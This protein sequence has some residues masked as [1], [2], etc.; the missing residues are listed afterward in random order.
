M[1]ND[2]GARF[3]IGSVEFAVVN[4]G[5]NYYDAGA[6]FGV[7]PRVMWERQIPPLDDRY[8]MNLGLNCLL[9]RSQGQT[10][11][12]ESGI[13]GKPGD[14][15]SASPAAIAPRPNSRRGGGNSSTTMAS[16]TGT[17]PPP[18]IACSALDTTSTSNVGASA[19]AALPTM[20]TPS[21]AAKMRRRP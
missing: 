15:D 10:I 19:T 5:I 4:D 18:P 20:N 6:I 9:L 11:L 17:T 21:A 8:R 16:A 13:G 3:A 7:V 12:I 14:R 2:S 1:Q